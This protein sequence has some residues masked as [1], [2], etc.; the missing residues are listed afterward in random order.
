MIIFKIL[1]VI[2]IL[3]L[4]G[5][6]PNPWLKSMT[7]LSPIS[8]DRIQVTMLKNSYPISKPDNLKSIKEKVEPKKKKKSKK[9]NHFN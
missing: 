6:N 7:H 3:K 1:T 2:N 8:K 5:T 9:W 4:I